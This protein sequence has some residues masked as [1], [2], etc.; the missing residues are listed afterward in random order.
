MWTLPQ[1]PKYLN[2][3]STLVHTEQNIQKMADICFWEAKRDIWLLLTG[4][5][6][7]CT[8]KSTLWSLFMILGN[9]FI[10]FCLLLNFCL[11][12]S[13]ALSIIFLKHS[14]KMSFFN[15]I[16]RSFQF[17]CCGIVRYVC[18][19]RINFINFMMQLLSL[20][21]F[22]SYLKVVLL[23]VEYSP[24][25]SVKRYSFEFQFFDTTRHNFFLY[26]I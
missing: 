5:Q 9:A 14:K 25:I 21:L 3:N 15:I 1:L 8:V 18:H 10:Y 19:L 12:Q 4:L 23:P 24:V 26:L 7:N 2:Y 16:I 11:Q 13:L 17:L 20:S 6:K 22:S